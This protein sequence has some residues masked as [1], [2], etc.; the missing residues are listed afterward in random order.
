MTDTDWNIIIQQ[1]RN[2]DCILMLGPEISSD[3][4]KES[5][6]PLIQL[7]HQEIATELSDQGGFDYDKLLNSDF[8]HVTSIYARMNTPQELQEVVTRFYKKYQEQKNCVHCDLASLPFSLIVNTTPDMMFES[9]LK[10]IK[11]GYLADYYDYKGPKRDTIPMGNQAQP[12]IYHLYGSCEQPRSLVLSENDLI[13]FLV[14]VISKAPPL[15]NNLKT[16]FNDPDKCFLFLGFG[17][18]VKNWYLRILLNVLQGSS[19]KSRSYA[20]EEFTNVDDP[21]IKNAIVFFT[22]EYKIKFFKKELKSFASE[23]K[24]RYQNEIQDSPEV[25]VTYRKDAPTIFICHTSEDNQFAML[26]NNELKNREIKTWIDKEQIRGGNDWNTQI[27]TTINE[28][29]GFVVL[30]SKALQQ[31]A[32]GYVNKEIKLALKRSEYYRDINFVYPV[33][34]DEGRFK[35]DEFRDRQSFDLTKADQ[36]DALAREI[37]RNHQRRLMLEHGG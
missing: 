35:L 15:P 14:A 37:K 2:N 5:D 32:V 10:N 36:I 13:E 1:I 8:E 29:D 17:F 33:I 23:L 9:A 21:G 4:P 12:L 26:L 25:A 20:M 34:V 19:R 6:K 30:Q 27:E 22:D 28:V 18:G 31:K 3:L 24:K 7:L 11:K 16:E